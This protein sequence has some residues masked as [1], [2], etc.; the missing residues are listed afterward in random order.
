MFSEF[1][2]Y[3]QVANAL[4]EIRHPQQRLTVDTRWMQA[5]EMRM[6]CEKTLRDGIPNGL[7]RDTTGVED[8]FLN[9]LFI[10]HRK[11]RTQ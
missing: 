8:I 6:M 5:A 2:S 4:N 9:I 7:L 11:C 3:L 1:D 10:Q